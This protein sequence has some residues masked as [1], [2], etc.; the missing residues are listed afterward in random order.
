VSAGRVND[1]RGFLRQ[2]NNSQS[3]AKT[4]MEKRELWE[5]GTTYSITLVRLCVPLRQP[6]RKGKCEAARGPGEGGA[7]VRGGHLPIIGD[8]SG[9]FPRAR[10]VLAGR[11]GIRVLQEGLW[12]EW[13]AYRGRERAQ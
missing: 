12:R 2:A 6:E 13:Q 1:A 4:T 5:K 9:R 7:S 8:W 10:R 11:D 3:R